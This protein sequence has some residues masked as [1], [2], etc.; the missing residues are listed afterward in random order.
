MNV[1]NL[2]QE[3]N[4]ARAN[5]DPAAA[6]RCYAQAFVEDPDNS[7]AFNNYGNVLREM[8]FPTRAVPFLDHARILDPNSITAK[9]NLSVAHLLSG[10]YEQ[11]WPLYESRWQYEH[12]AD[13]KPKLPKPE[14]TGEDL[15]GKTLLIIGEQ[16]LGDQIQFIRFLGDL[17][18]LGVKI[19]LHV[20]PGLKPLFESSSELLL[21][22]TSDGD[23]LGEFDYWTM[24][25]SLP[26]RLGIKL[27]DLTPHL[28]YI[29]P[30]QTATSEW[31][32]RL[33]PK[34]KMRIGFVW[35]GR[36]DSWINQHKSIPFDKIVSLIEQNP[37][38]QWINLQVDC[39]KEEGDKLVEIGA[40]CFPGT[41]RNFSDT[42]ALVANLDLVISVDT[43]VAHLAGAMGRPTWIPL[44][45]YGPCWRWLLN[46]D[47]SPWYPS[48][49]LFR[50]PAYRDWDS[51]MKKI[52]Q[53]LSWFKV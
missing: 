5:H 51:V 27:S 7:A 23:N 40:Q 49:R 50:Q 39:S 47:D 46:R 48:V 17:H 44:N 31:S 1:D 29:I 10:N 30:D 15:N 45:S 18:H 32:K 52:S 37:Q 35:S 9:F 53:F 43:A 26:Y 6:I 33:G 16:G 11:G 3:G 20:S 14:W 4:N 36:R 38:Y 19:R 8:G 2:I 24:M 41:I 21:S 13:T 22:V 25:M 34:N 12:L 28:Q 42:A